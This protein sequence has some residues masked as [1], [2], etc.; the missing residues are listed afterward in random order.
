VRADEWG[1]GRV[2]VEDIDEQRTTLAGF[3]NSL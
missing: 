2:P 3:F 1:G